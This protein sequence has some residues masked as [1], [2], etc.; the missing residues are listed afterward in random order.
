MKAVFISDA[1]LTRAADERYCQLINFFDDIK[2]GKV[3]SFTEEGTTNRQP[4]YI[5]DLY[6]V[7]DFFDFWFCRREK[8][9]PEFHLI[10]T[11]LMELQ[12]AG[13]RIHLSEGNHDFYLGEYFHDVLGMEVFEEWASVK[14]DNLRVLL[15]HGDT[16]DRANTSYLLFRKFL[17]SRAFYNF[18]RI[19]PA[20][21]RWGLASLSSKASKEMTVDNAEVMVEK[22]L[23]FALE[24]F[25][26]DYDAIILG[27]CHKPVLRHY[28]VEGRKKTFVTL[29]DWIRHYSFL[30][31]ENKKFVLGYY[32]PR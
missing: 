28:E 23:A 2:A 9:Y 13:V 19:I 4:V 20:S 16:A 24:K 25:Q 21:V 29:G 14:L 17:R 26:I 1:H 30:Y 10:I 3:T 5:N 27:H 11:K 12:K 18:Q 32:Q 22:M 31:Y 8:I 7:G 15:A 6:I